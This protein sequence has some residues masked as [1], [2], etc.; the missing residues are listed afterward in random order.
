[1]LQ[2][3]TSLKTQ[4]PKILVKQI[5]IVL[6]RAVIQKN[7]CLFKNM[8]WEEISFLR[9]IMDFLECIFSSCTSCTGSGHGCKWCHIKGYCREATEDC[10]Q[11][12]RQT[13]LHLFFSC[14]S[15][16]NNLTC[17]FILHLIGAFSVLKLKAVLDFVRKWDLGA[18][19]KLFLSCISTKLHP[20]TWLVW[21]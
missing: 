18:R 21:R 19:K 1:M 5:N 4:P 20:I 6:L 12:V 3:L 16:L 7:K 10:P 14:T 11:Q 2:Q 8:L 9:Q 13:F 15:L 17:L